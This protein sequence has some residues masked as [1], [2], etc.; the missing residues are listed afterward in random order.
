MAKINLLTIHFSENT[1]AALQTYATCKILKHLGHQ[2]TIIDLRPISHRWYKRYFRREMLW[3]LPIILRF[4]AFRK[5]FYPPMTSRMLNIDPVQIPDADYYIV[6]SDQTWNPSITK[7]HALNYYLD[8]VSASRP[9]IAL[10]SSFGVW[11]WEQPPKLTEAVR[12]ELKKFRA[13]AVREPCGVEICNSVFGVKAEVIPDPALVW[14]DYREITGVIPETSEMVAYVFRWKK[15]SLFDH[16]A[17]D[18]IEFSGLPMRFLTRRGIRPGRLKPYLGCSLLGRIEP[19]EWLQR[20]GGAQLVVTDSFHGTVF[21]LLFHRQFIVLQFE[22]PRFARIAELL[23]SL[24]LGR[25]CVKSP[26]DLRKR[27]TEIFAP[28]DYHEVEPLIARKRATYWA[29]LKDNIANG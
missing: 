17:S 10:A 26:E 5:R 23:D 29:F 25:L 1:G 14:E 28:I 20:I 3:K 19:R 4:R 27:R 18:L 7:S 16:V 22:S 13:I 2:V 24:G 12:S 11:T 9:R 8:F 21:S 6:G 15:G